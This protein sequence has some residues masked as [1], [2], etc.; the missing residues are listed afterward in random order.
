MFLCSLFLRW[1]DLKSGVSFTFQRTFRNLFVN[2]KQPKT[3]KLTVFLGLAIPFSLELFIAPSNYS[4]L[5]NSH[6]LLLFRRVLF[7]SAFFLS[8]LFLIAHG[9]FSTNFVYVG[10]KYNVYKSKSLPERFMVKLNSYQSEPKTFWQIR[11][12][13]QNQHKGTMHASQFF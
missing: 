5:L 10:Y 9:R 13:G 4:Q 11:R 7:F 6:Q 3:Q 8:V 1:N 12:S 2:G